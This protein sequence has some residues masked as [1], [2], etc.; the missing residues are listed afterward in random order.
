MILEIREWSKLL[1]GIT[2]NRVERVNR[3]NNRVTPTRQEKKS[4]YQLQEQSDQH[5]KQTQG[6]R[7]AKG[8]ESFVGIKMI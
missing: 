4:E 6:V 7:W 2:H 1:S 8:E 3:S 5:L